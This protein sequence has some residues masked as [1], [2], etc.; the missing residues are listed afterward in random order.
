MSD[1]N[2]RLYHC[3]VQK[4][5]YFKSSLILARIRH[6]AKIS[7]STRGDKFSKSPKGAKISKSTRGD[8]FSKSPKGAKFLSPLVEIN[9]Q[10]PPKS[11]RG[12]KFSKSP[13]GA[14]FLSPLVE[15][16]FQSP[17]K[18]RKFLSPLVEVD[19]QSSSKVRKFLSSLVEVQRTTEP[20]TAQ[21]CC[22]H[23]KPTIPTSHVSLKSN[24]LLYICITS[25]LIL[26]RI[27]SAKI[28]KFTGRSPTHN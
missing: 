8:K 7:K 16:N 19:F 15:I 25:S 20:G 5:T 18:V 17:P 2:T 1:A 3:N 21:L 26:A 4:Y 12:D 27:A 13:K 23:S 24:K 14:K 28:S 9:F 6:R 22:R 10:S 11:T